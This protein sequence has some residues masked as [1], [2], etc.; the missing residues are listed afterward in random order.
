MKSR[1]SHSK[2]G[3]STS[4]NSNGIF[5]FFSNAWNDTQKNSKNMLDS[6]IGKKTITIT[7]PN[8]N[9]NTNTNVSNVSSET[10]QP[11]TSSTSITEKENNMDKVGGKKKGGGHASV[12]GLEVAKPT[13]WIK[14]GRKTK[15][16]KRNKTNK[17]RLNK[18]KSNKRM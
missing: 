10:Q 3:D 8:P 16:N 15:R 5:S 17:K 12:H 1:R 14:G 7:N 6:L 2:G 18:R 9:P 13:Y 11:I 4:S